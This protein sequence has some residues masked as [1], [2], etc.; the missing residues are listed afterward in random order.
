[1][2]KT[3]TLEVMISIAV[4][5]NGEVEMCEANSYLMKRQQA[6]KTWTEKLR[7]SSQLWHLK[8]VRVAVPLPVSFE[9]QT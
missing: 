4:S 1:M 2:A 6:Y 3:P 8:T 5:E 7:A 9:D